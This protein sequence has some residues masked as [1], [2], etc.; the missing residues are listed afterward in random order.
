[1]L[2]ARIESTTHCM[3]RAFAFCFANLRG[4]FHSA[5][6]G[7]LNSENPH[8]QCEQSFQDEQQD[9]LRHSDGSPRAV[10]KD[11]WGLCLYTC[12][13]DTA[14]ACPA[15]AMPL[16]A[17]V[18]PLGTAVASPGAAASSGAVPLIA[19]AAPLRASVPPQAIW[20]V[21]ACPH[22]PCRICVPCAPIM[23]PPVEDFPMDKSSSPLF[24][25]RWYRLLK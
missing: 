1:M 10:Q 17:A 19:A 7:P 11:H 5:A 15:A 3:V 9:L 16:G 23:L 12:L 14:S 25:G 6:Q 21:L 18:V 20:I 2:P 8:D 22:W 24:L 13:S 4:S